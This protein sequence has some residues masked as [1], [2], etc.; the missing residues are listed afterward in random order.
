M[1]LIGDTRQH[2]SIEAGRIFEQLQDAGMQ[3]A[4]L[5]RIVRQ[6]EEGLRHVVEAM[7]AG[8]VEQGV[9]STQSAGPDPFE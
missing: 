4:Q 5:T 9:D 2:Q 7:A 3:T 1:L 6:K 8:Q